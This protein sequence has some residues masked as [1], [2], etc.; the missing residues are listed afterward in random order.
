MKHSYRQTFQ[1]NDAVVEYESRFAAG[2]YG[3]VLSD[4]EYQF[5]DQLLL[6]YPDPARLSYLDFACGT[7]RIISHVEGQVGSS[8]G[9]DVAQPMLDVA[10]I[11]LRRSRLVCKDVAVEGDVPEATYDLITSFRFFLNAEPPLRRRVMHALASRL[12][13]NDSRL[14]FSVQGILDS[15]K[16]LSWAGHQV[17]AALSGRP[18]GMRAMSMMTVRQ[19]V[20]EADLE[21]EEVFGYDVLSGKAQHI[22]GLDRLGRVE[23]RLAGTLLARL[24]GGHRIIVAR[25]QQSSSSR[26]TAQ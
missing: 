9:I 8:V 6:R 5:L 25:R 14:V 13:A 17:K 22:L 26:A 1:G 18:T 11:K 7:G 12:R 16:L 20:A 4:I 24:A 10:Q 2:K 3:R 21:I 15:H 23:H 19:L